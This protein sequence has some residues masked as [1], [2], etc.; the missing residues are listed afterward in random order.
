MW[1]NYNNELHS[2]VCS[3]SQNI[4]CGRVKLAPLLFNEE[5]WP[6]AVDWKRLWLAKQYSRWKVQNILIY[7]V[8]RRKMI[9]NGCKQLMRFLFVIV[10][11]FTRHII[12]CITKIRNI[13]MLHKNIYSDDYVRDRIIACRSS[14]TV[15][16]KWKICKPRPYLCVALN[17][18]GIY[19]HFCRRYICQYIDQLNGSFRCRFVVFHLF[20][21]KLMNWSLKTGL[22]QIHHNH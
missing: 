7:F 11:H 6:W 9:E 21:A 19:R 5:K 22:R 4:H 3:I 2:I 20:C 13:K 18:S 1:I 8:C 15:Q 16:A 10:P 12:F 14:G 17:K